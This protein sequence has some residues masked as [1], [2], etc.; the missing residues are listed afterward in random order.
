MGKNG[1]KLKPEQLADLAKETDFTGDEI[2][3]W[4]KGFHR[5]CPS[6]KLSVEEFKRIY[7]NFFP[8]GDASRFAG[9][10]FRTFDKDG[11]QTIDFQVRE[12]AHLSARHAHYGYL[13]ISDTPPLPLV[14]GYG[15]TLTPDNIF[16]E[17]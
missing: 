16:R 15:P 10:V 11:S 2:E 12:N 14:S 1:S 9:H 6:G 7:G 8:Y 3:Q 13:R 17:S 4:Y 5:D